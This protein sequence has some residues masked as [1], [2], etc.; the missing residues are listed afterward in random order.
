MVDELVKARIPKPTVAKLIDRIE[1]N[2]PDTSEND[3]KWTRLEND[4]HWLKWAIAL[5]FSALVALMF[6]IVGIVTYLHN[7]MKA[8]IHSVRTGMKTE[9]QSIRTEIQSVR[10]EMKTE[11]NSLRTEISS[12]IDQLNAKIDQILVRRR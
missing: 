2:E 10:T 9:M 4:V 1:K 7:D 11:I 5:G 6:G 8:E 12:K 3:L